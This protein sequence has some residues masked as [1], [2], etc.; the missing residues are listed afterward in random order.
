MAQGIVQGRL[1]PGLLAQQHVYD[2][3]AGDGGHVI[4]QA[5]LARGRQPAKIQ[6]EE[7]HHQQGQ[8][9]HRHGV[10]DEA[11]GHDGEIQG[12]PLIEG[13]QGTERDPQQQ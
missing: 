6:R 8:P 2:G 7:H 12:A 1:P 11:G 3:D 10:A 9:E 5:D 4:E 13:S